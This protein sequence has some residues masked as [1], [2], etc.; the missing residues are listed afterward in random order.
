MIFQSISDDP[1]G[2]E[3]DRQSRK[4]KHRPENQRFVS[5]DDRMKQ[6]F[7]SRY[8]GLC[9][10]DLVERIVGLV[11]KPK[12]VGYPAADQKSACGCLRASKPGQTV[13][14]F[15]GVRARLA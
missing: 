12:L 11:E 15:D 8:D 2:K 14:V 5:T 9:L 3:P 4:K 6:V 10:V 13:G 1:V 7:D